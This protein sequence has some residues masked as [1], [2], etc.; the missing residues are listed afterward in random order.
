MNPTKLK[1][2]LMAQ[3]RPHHV[4]VTS[5]DGA[6]HEVSCVGAT[7]PKITETV[8]ALSPEMIQAYTNDN[9]LI[10][11]VRPLDQSEDWA[12]DDSDPSGP[13]VPPLHNIPIT[14]SDPETQRFALVAHL[15][16]EAYRHS[17]Q[18]AFDKLAAITEQLMLRSTDTERARDS[19][20]R[21]HIKQLEDQIKAL[22]EEPAGGPQEVIGQM[23]AAFMGGAAQHSP[24]PPPAPHATTNG[25]GTHA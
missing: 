13:R 9:K 20:Y 4:Q 22:G 15:I 21:A 2:W 6:V 12:D 18:V 19:V 5:V 8:A 10:R 23:L 14:A 3:P 11:A 25:K 7:W 16:S 1:Q 24:P 17:T